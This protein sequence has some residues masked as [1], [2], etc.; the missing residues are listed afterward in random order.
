MCELGHTHLILG[1]SNL[2]CWFMSKNG[3][4]HGPGGRNK[5]VNMYHVI[6]K[7]II[8]WN[9]NLVIEQRSKRVYR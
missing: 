6:A 5:I 8:S 2:I 4:D 3:D 1:H 9:R 7:N